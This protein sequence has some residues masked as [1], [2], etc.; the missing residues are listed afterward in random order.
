MSSPLRFHHFS[1]QLW[2]AKNRTSVPS[3]RTCSISRTS[4]WSQRGQSMASNRQRALMLRP[5]APLQQRIVIEETPYVA[6]APSARFGPIGVPIGPV[7]TAVAA[8]LP[9]SDHLL[10]HPDLRLVSV[11]NGSGTLELSPC[12]DLKAPQ[13]V[14]IEVFDRVEQIAVER[15][16]ATW[17]GANRRVAVRRSV[18]VQPWGGVI[19]SA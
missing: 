12:Q 5:D 13:V 3:G 17:T 16:Q 15:H 9:A 7:R 19:R 11:L 10:S 8:A 4:V 18:S 1:S 2:H 6:A 14:L